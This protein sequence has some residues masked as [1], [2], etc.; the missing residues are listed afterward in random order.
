MRISATEQ[1]RFLN[2][3]WT[4]HQTADPMAQKRTKTAMATKSGVAGAVMTGKT[5]SGYVA[6]AEPAN[7]RRSDTGASSPAT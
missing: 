2:R 6:L 3:L 5:G 1:V 4:G 7:Q